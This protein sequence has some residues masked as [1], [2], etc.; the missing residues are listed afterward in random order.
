MKKSNLRIFFA[1]IAFIFAFSASGV[2]AEPETDAAQIKDRIRTLYGQ[3][4]DYMREGKSALAREA[5]L[6]IVELNPSESTAYYY[7]GSLNLEK[8]E[9]EP[10][11]SFLQ[12]AVDT[13]RS[14]TKTLYVLAVVLSECGQF[15]RSK[16][17]YEQILKADPNHYAAHHDLG[18][19]YYRTEDMPASIQHLERAVEIDPAAKKSHFMLGMAWIKHGKPENALGVVTMLR[20][21]KAEN[22]ATLVE[23]M[24][25][26]FRENRKIPDPS[27]ASFGLPPLEIPAP[28]SGPPKSESEIA[29]GDRGQS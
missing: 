15:E 14:D 3:A 9:L 24:I 25:R 1:S 18:V 22:E 16:G 6:K 11:A 17:V 4:S 12:K 13:G 5:L 27:S 7:L 20:Q 26:D 19:L 8:R 28:P 2:A 23:R 10:A 29:S 21:M